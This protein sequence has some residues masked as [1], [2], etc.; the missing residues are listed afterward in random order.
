MVEGESGLLAIFPPHLRPVYEP[1][2]R[3]ITFRNGALVTT[4][5]GDEPDLLRGPQHDT[6]WA[7][8]V[9]TW[10]YPETWDN[11]LLGLRLG[12]DPRACVTT[13]P[14]PKA[15]CRILRELIDDAATVVTR[16]STRE[17]APNLAPTFLSQVL[18]R[19]Q[20][21]R[22]ERQE[23]D[24]ELLEDFPGALWT[25]EMLAAARLERAVPK[26]GRLVVAVDPAASATQDSDETGVVV[27]AKGEDGHGYV[28]DDRSGVL[29]PDAW[30]RRAIGAYHDFGADLIVAEKNQG[31]DMVRHVIRS[32][33]PTVPVKLVSATRGKHVR[34]EPV[35]ALYER[36][37]VHHA[38]PFARLEDQ[39]AG[40]TF[41]G[42]AGDASPDRADALV[43]A[44]TELFHGAWGFEALDLSDEQIGGKKPRKPKADWE[45]RTKPD[46]GDFVDREF[47]DDDDNW[48]ETWNPL[49]PPPDDD[50]ELDGWD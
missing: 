30:A 47:Q 31:G 50:E 4:Y 27:A 45:P 6:L 28:L 16:G 34:A 32:L 12:R 21:T 44:L 36:G 9:A 17:N 46:L 35:S 2:K 15:V 49:G 7:D 20:G 14:K 42:Y 38:K 40:F 1:S 23:I 10:R 8:E 3:R 37:L 13:T 25:V 18:R 26:L 43:W 24:G 41:E 39:L 33:D 22:L 5:S 19:Y 48:P 11:A 29:M